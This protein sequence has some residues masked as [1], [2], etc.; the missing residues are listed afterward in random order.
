MSLCGAAV[1]TAVA[2]VCDGMG[3]EAFGEYAAWQAVTALAEWSERL[4]LEE[5]L[6][7]QVRACVRDMNRR[8]C[9]EAARRGCRMG[10]TLVLAVLRGERAD[11][12]N[13]G[14]SRAYHFSRGELRRL[15]VDHTAA[16]ALLSMGLKPSEKGREHNQLTQYLGI[17]ESELL[18]EA[19]HGWTQLGRGDRLL[20]CSDGLSDTLEEREIALVLS[21]GAPPEVQALRLTRHAERAGGR[22][23]VTALVIAAGGTDKER[24]EEG[25]DH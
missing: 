21:D 7:G 14:D 2:A 16:Q 4:R 1:E 19:S 23:N 11:I 3:G 6:D 22:D 24:V 17:P 20:L 10:S 25:H 15:S 13:I 12:Y 9:A 8:I 18:L 5:D